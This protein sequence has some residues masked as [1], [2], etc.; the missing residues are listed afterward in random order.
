MNREDQRL[1]A[2]RALFAKVLA[3]V[4][5][6]E[7][8]RSRDM[9][10]PTLVAGEKV[11]AVLPD[12][13]VVGTVQLTEPPASVGVT[14]YDAL[15]AYVKRTRPDEVLNREYIRESYLN[16]LKAMAK[17]Q[18]AED[19]YGGEVVDP[20]GE[21]VPGLDMEY[22]RPRYLPSLTTAGRKAVKGALARLLGPEL[23]ERLALPR[24]EEA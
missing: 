12:G 17:E 14:D 13:T 8:R 7:V 19:T 23:R 24:G 15:L 10:E 21:V 22:G 3:E 11:K 4:A 18:L 6:A 16:H 5:D 1:A 20:H 9:V 2:G